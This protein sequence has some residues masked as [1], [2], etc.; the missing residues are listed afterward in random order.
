MKKRTENARP[1]ADRKPP[2]SGYVKPK[3]KKYGDLRA[4]TAA[5]GSSRRDG[6]QPKTWNSGGF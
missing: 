6:G 4:L 1:G 5:K 2:A 3:L